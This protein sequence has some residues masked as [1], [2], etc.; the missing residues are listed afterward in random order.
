[1]TDFLEVPVVPS[2]PA[3]SMQVL[4]EE[5]TYSLRFRFNARLGAWFVEVRDADGAMLAAPRRI[6]A[7]W[8]LWDQYRYD[9]DVPQGL[10]LAF[11]TTLQPLT[12]GFFSELAAGAAVPKGQFDILLEPQHEGGYPL[13]LAADEGLVLCNEILM[14]AGGTARVVFEIDWIERATY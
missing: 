3:Y 13:V 10:L 4:L 11:D 12:S 1:M 7:D 14:G 8:G 9:P 2:V 6:V 5:A